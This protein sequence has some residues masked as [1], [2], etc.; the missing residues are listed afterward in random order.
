MNWLDIVLLL[1]LAWS[2]ATSFRKG[3]TR[4]VL[5]LA[6][7]VVAFLLALW[8]Y[9]TA[10][11]Y[12]TPYV[13]SRSLANLAG[14]LA[15]FAAVM[16]LGSLVGFIVGKFLR[17]TGLSIVD[18]ALGAAFGA[19]RG[20]LI[21][22]VLIMAIMAFST[23]DRPRLEL[24]ELGLEGVGGDVVE[25]ALHDLLAVVGNVERDFLELGALRDAHANFLEARKGTRFGVAN[26]HRQ[27]RL[28]HIEVAH[29][30]FQG[31]FVEGGLLRRVGGAEQKGAQ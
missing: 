14:F 4:E 8:F 2:I 7:V 27:L 6:S 31:R 22:I 23:G 15:V 3:L 29:I 19:L 26:G 17:V 12:L 10:G 1:I 18:H 24:V 20:T 5:G 28:Q 30:G 9:G 21:A 13:S 11:A 16:L 25:A